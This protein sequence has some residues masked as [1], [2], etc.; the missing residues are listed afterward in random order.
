[1][2][3]YRCRLSAIRASAI[4]VITRSVIS[5]HGGRRSTAMVLI[6]AAANPAHTPI[7]ACRLVST[8]GIHAVFSDLT[9]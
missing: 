5:G 3:P 2:K 1:M 4:A 8:A 6:T 7:N 9:E